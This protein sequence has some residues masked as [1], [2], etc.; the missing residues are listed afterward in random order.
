MNEDQFLRAYQAMRPEIERHLSRSFDTETASDLANETFARVWQARGTFDPDRGSPR[1]W[2]YG[3]TR[4]VRT[5]HQ[6]SLRHEPKSTVEQ[7]AESHE[8]ASID[9]VDAAVAIGVVGAALAGLGNEDF[10]V[11]SPVIIACLGGFEV[12]RRS[13]ADHLRLHRLRH[14]LRRAIES[15]TGEQPAR[16][17]SPGSA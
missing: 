7:A 2:I 8:S 10:Q 17:P 11:I 6:R 5:Q 12:A 1:Q 9:R 15:G 13:N 3:I 16:S 14:R 4:N